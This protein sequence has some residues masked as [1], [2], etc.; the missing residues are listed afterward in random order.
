[1]LA[2][3]QALE[4]DDAD[5]AALPDWMRVFDE[6][7]YIYTL[8]GGRGSGKS[9]GAAIYC[10][11]YARAHSG[12][13]ILCAREIQKNVGESSWRTLRTLIR[14]LGW[15]SVF[16]VQA[17]RI[18]CINGSEFV[19]RGL[20]ESHGTAEGIKSLEGVDLTWVE[21][22]EAITEPSLDLLLPTVLRRERSHILFTL[23]PLEPD[24]AVYQRYVL[25][26]VDG[27]VVRQVN[28]RDNPWFPARLE[29]ERAWME[30][31]KPHEYRHVYEGEPRLEVEGALWSQAMLAEARLEA[32]EYAALPDPDDV[33]VAVDPAFSTGEK[34]DFTGIVV[35][36]R[37][38]RNGYVLHAERGKYTAPEWARRAVALWRQFRASRVAIEA[39]GAD[40]PLLLT[41]RQVDSAVPV[42]YVSASGKGSK[43]DRAGPVAN[44]YLPHESAE[45]GRI[46]HVGSF[47]EL[48][49][50]QLSFT[51]DSVRDDLVDSLVWATDEL[52]LTRRTVDLSTWRF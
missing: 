23:N 33:V 50:E 39:R 20:S 29:P 51:R 17:T 37:I 21:Q 35:L 11:E 14:L 9:W 47:G 48:E 36:A 12:A 49:G 8:H 16:E 18:Q 52:G 28:W 5:R 31:H 44:L 1:M 40:D 41:V 32:G 30:R 7:G 24:G 43:V 38:G 13:L 6:P 15:G 42:A 10:L 2:S 4:L 25:G 3:Q 34:S 46:Y 26:D 22:A 19:F 27:A 45:Y